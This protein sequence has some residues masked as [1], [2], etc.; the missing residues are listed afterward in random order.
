MPTDIPEWSK[1]DRRVFENEILPAGRPAV[2]KALA[3][4]WPLVQRHTDTAAAITDYLRTFNPGTEVEWLAAE[5]KMNGRFFYNDAM[6]GMNF[7]RVRG[8]FGHALSLL[9]RHVADPAPPALAL[10][11]LPLSVHMPRFDRQHRLDL[12][13][14][15]TRA[16][17]WI[18]N[19]LTVAAHFDFNENIACVAHGR[20][21]FMLFPPEQLENLYV[22][23]LEFTPQGVPISLVDV[24]NPDLER[25]PR[26]EQAAAAAQV[27]EL[28]AGDAI[29]IPYM[30][31][32]SVRSMDP[33]NVLIN[34]WWNAVRRPVVS[35]FH[36]LLHGVIAIANLPSPQRDVWKRFFDHYVFR[37]H[38]DPAEHIAPQRRG[39]LG[40]L[41]PDQAEQLTAVLA[42]LL[43]E[44]R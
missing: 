37:A 10:Q 38:G 20:R 4:H 35:P 12:P 42:H 30:W 43:R 25:Y 7:H 22:G 33:F 21:R 3:D 17:M 39:L 23:P 26:F 29:F 31:W 18:G 44:T 41:S 28:E 36:S 24:H 6:D 14:P 9:V 5:P 13:P 34:Y 27:A 2:F 11:A 8:T 16:T 15:E 32:H 19:A 40:N 1:V